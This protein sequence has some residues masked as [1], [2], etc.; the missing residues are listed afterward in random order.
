MHYVLVLHNACSIDYLAQNN[1]HLCHLLF[2][3]QVRVRHVSSPDHLI[4]NFYDIVMYISNSIFHAYRYMYG[5]GNHYYGVWMSG[6]SGLI[7]YYWKDLLSNKQFRSALHCSKYM[8]LRGPLV[9][10]GVWTEKGPSQKKIS[11]RAI[12][13]SLPEPNRHPLAPLFRLN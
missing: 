3:V 1:M 11:A 4:H 2:S 8:S 7:P 13:E 6:Q 9:R 5:S 10:S 12:S